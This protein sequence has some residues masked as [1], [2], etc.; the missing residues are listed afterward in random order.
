MQ[1]EHPEVVENDDILLSSSSTDLAVLG[2]RTCQLGALGLGDS[3]QVKEEEG[4]S[5][6][7]P[8]DTLS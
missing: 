2:S 3:G 7:W 5:S 4:G 6:A 8:T 1:S